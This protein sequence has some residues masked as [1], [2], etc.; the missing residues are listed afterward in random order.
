MV[1]LKGDFPCELAAVAQHGPDW[2]YK[3]LQSVG[4]GARLVADVLNVVESASLKN[5]S[6]SC[7]VSSWVS[8]QKQCHWCHIEQTESYHV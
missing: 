2:L 5:I 7:I 8:M 4:P 6:S 3:T 1:H